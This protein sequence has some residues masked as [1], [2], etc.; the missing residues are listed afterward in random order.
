[1]SEFHYEAKFGYIR[2]AGAAQ[3][4]WYGRGEDLQRRYRRWWPV[5]LWQCLAVLKTRGVAEDE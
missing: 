2:L 1:M 5:A 3:I 4:W